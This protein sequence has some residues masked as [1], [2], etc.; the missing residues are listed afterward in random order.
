[1]IN[2]FPPLDDGLADAS[3]AL[4]R[5]WVEESADH[6]SSASAQLLAKM[7]K[8]PAGL[9]FTSAFIDRVIRPTDARVAGT[10]L[11]RVVGEHS[12]A[13]LPLPMRVAARLGAVA[14]PI[15]PGL[16]VPLARRV[17]RGLV[18]HLVAD[19]R[20][21]KLGQAIAVLSRDGRR[22]NLNL[23]GE[24]V[25]GD[26]EADRRF[27]GTM[28]LL[29]RPDVDYVSIKVSSVSSQLSMWDWNGT[30]AQVVHKIA[31]LYELAAASPTPKFINLDME[32][33]RDLD[34]TVAVFTTLLD[35]PR[36]RDLRAGI[37]L[38]AYLPDT[39]AVLQRLTRWARQ[40]V[41]DG[42]API[43]VRVVKGANLSM[44]RLESLVHSWPSAPFAS[45][46]QTDTNYK[47][48]LNWGFQPEVTEAVSF[49]VA[50][51]NLFDVAFAHLLA[52]QRG[53]ADQ[54]EHEMLLG[55]AEGQQDVIAR[56]VGGLLL[57]TPVVRPSEFDVAIS[58]LIRRLEENASPENFMSAVFDLAAD[59]E[60][61]AREE[62]RFRTSLDAVDGVVPTPNRLQNRDLD[63]PGEPQQRF[64]NVPDTDPALPGN[65]KWID[66]IIERSV[67]SDLGVSLVAARRIETLDQAESAVR[68]AAAAGGTWADR[69]AAERAA[70][71]RRAAV[72]FEARRAEFLEVAAAETGKV[73]AETDPEVSEAIDFLNYYAER[74]PE[75]ETVPGADYQPATVTVAAPPWNF[76]V[77]IPTGSV[78]GPLA[79]GSAVIM[80]P[81]PQAQRCGALIAETLWQAGVPEDVLQL[82]I[83]P[84]DEV[85]RRLIAHPQVDCVVLTGAYE[86]ARLFASWRPGLKVLA[87]TSGKNS[88]IVTPSCDVDQA[89]AHLVHSA[90]SHAG[91]KC[92]AASLGILVGSMADN[93]RFAR[94]L[95]DATR[96]LVVGWPSDPSAKVGPVV[97]PAE[98]KLLRG[99]TELGPGERWLLRPRSLD[100][101]GRLWS[102]G[103]RT[104]VR[105]GSDFHRTEFFGPVLGLMAADSLDQAIDFQNG[106]DYGLTAG[107]ETLDRT[108]LERWSERVEAGNLYVNRGITGAVVRRQSFGG[109]KRSSIGAGAKAGGPNYL[110]RLGHWRRNDRTAAPDGATVLDVP[111]ARRIDRL[112][113][114]GV[115]ADWLQAA[116]ISDLAV[117]RNVFAVAA[118]PD[119]L[120]LERNLFRYRPVPVIIRAGSGTPEIE[121]VR[122]ILAGT[123]AG[124][125]MTVCCAEE[126]SS[127][128]RD[129]VRE[130]GAKMIIKRERS[131]LTSAAEL[132]R[133]SGPAGP[134]IRLLGAQRSSL[135]L[136]LAEA[137]I[138]HPDIAVYADEVTAAGRI[139]L[140]PFLR[141]QAISITA[142]RFGVTD[143]WSDTVIG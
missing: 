54:V 77:A 17:V 41:A 10:N 3:V 20:P 82:V 69:G 71:L 15:A 133:V 130:V 93:E 136:A 121:L 132:A 140:L 45:K 27:A 29:A 18:G 28:D 7:L 118:D 87:E 139:E 117:W 103:I 138:D 119:H 88:I 34:L 33:Y 63:E 84:E 142:N 60:A 9:A 96:S 55:M 11:S 44:E 141:E 91:Q 114:S 19:A 85:G 70:I 135:T 43:K 108:E 76:P 48:V 58:Y 115:D 107:L 52:V 12:P 97:E 80:K 14:A 57:Y 5:S 95:I 8:D 36:F 120:G 59:P 99:L 79:S 16:V 72:A 49:G 143:D 100:E 92:S 65:R 61:F 110:I 40:R 74:A 127:A 47:T 42:G 137:L 22:L 13:F 50:G 64:C 68:T 25:L 124:S 94:Q 62:R 56:D 90:F 113:L 131:W 123:R 116:A 129:L 30:V 32:D 109:W 21:H 125:P 128:V 101:S 66:K 105:P 111:T 46:V 122:T 51:H 38:Q 78:A 73:I 98:G 2:D 23:L 134:R 102:P 81:A 83:A 37:V 106:T 104:G 4:A 89:V 26:D 53:V 112:G 35:Q 126:S 86:T 75:L 67:D 6:P 31:P 24:A 1:M 39:L